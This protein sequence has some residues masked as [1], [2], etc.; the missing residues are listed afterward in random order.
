MNSGSIFFGG[1]M[2]SGIFT[3]TPQGA[4]LNRTPSLIDRQRP[5]MYGK[6]WGGRAVGSPQNLETERSWENFRFFLGGQR[7]GKHQTKIVVQVFNRLIF[8][9]K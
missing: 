9:K 4:V 6:P 1:G 8:Q 5:V 3:I 7:A 2:I